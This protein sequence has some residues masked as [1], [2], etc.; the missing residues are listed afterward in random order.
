V[1]DEA[2]ENP[3]ER[4]VALARTLLRLLPSIAKPDVEALWPGRHRIEIGGYAFALSGLLRQYDH[5]QT[6]IAWNQARN[7]IAQALHGVSDSARL[8]SAEPILTDLATWFS[9][10]TNRWARGEFPGAYDAVLLQEGIRLDDAGY[11][12]RPGRGRDDVDP[13]AI[14]HTTT[15]SLSDQLSS[16]I[17]NVT[18]MFL[19]LRDLTNPTAE[20]MYVRD[21][22]TGGLGSC[23]AEPWHLIFNGDRALESLH[24]MIS[25]TELLERTLAAQGA[26]D[27]ARP[28]ARRA[29]CAG[30]W[31]QALRRAAESIRP[32]QESQ[33]DQRCRA[34]VDAVAV[35]APD[36]DIEVRAGEDGSFTQFAV[37][38]EG[39][40]VYMFSTIES[41]IVAAVQAMS[42][43]LDKF[44]VLPTRMGKRLDGV[45]VSVI[46]S[47]LPALSIE[48][49]EDLVP[50]A[51]SSQLADLTKTVFR[52]L[53]IVS[54]IGELGE[55]GQSHPA[56][57]AVAG[58][59]ARS[60]REAISILADLDDDLAR[61]VVEAASEVAQ[62]V[63]NENPSTGE[64]TFAA[65]LVRGYLGDLTEEYAAVTVLHLSALE[66]PINE[67]GVRDLLDL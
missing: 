30:Q 59:A 46:Q 50:E 44:L 11:A 48:G 60:F 27:T 4:C 23:L 2:Q 47:P 8:A 57:L 22:L 56:V 58:A 37:L 12:L 18:A 33:L 51:H 43:T 1:S 14:T 53:Q 28:V 45:G 34:I 55:H 29:A 3:R 52:D 40:P 49:W 66:W 17:T 63:A 54:G 32:L 9:S 41:P 10:L 6:A 35:V 36:C 61:R 13:G 31:R 38:V 67:R 24:S 39:P 65:A 42:R 19:R 62:R 5:N 26:N 7:A 15:T 21:Q 25:T 64:E 16:T 20:A